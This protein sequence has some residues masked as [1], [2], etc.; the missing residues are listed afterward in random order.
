M[1]THTKEDLDSL[2]D[3]LSEVQGFLS[4]PYKKR[5]T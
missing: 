4:L 3:A 2:L 5:Q 1:S